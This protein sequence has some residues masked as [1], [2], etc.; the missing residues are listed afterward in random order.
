MDKW[1]IAA[2]SSCDLPAE[3]P[4]AKAPFVI[5]VGARDYVDD[6]LLDTEEML[7]DMEG[8]PEAS[9][10]SCPS[11]G[12][13]LELFERA[14]NVIAVTISQRLSGSYASAATAREIYLE[15][16]PGRRVLLINSRSTGPALALIVRRARELIYSGADFA[17]VSEALPAYAR[18]LRTAFAL[19]SFTNLVKNGRMSRL[20]GFVASKLGVWGIGVGSEEGEIAVKSRLRG[21]VKALSA[22]VDDMGSNGFDGGEVCI[23]H[24]F[25]PDAARTLREKIELR[26]RDAR[27]HILETRGLCSY[28]AERRGLILA[29]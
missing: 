29:Y 26:W 9:H 14:E 16:H 2:D 25:N 21:T 13:W 6:E 15:R 17:A 27:V 5:S 24:C 4:V 19:S 1:L 7:S 22:L 20:T 8:C 3:D 23:S 18:S 12:V 10:T 11:P 28:Y